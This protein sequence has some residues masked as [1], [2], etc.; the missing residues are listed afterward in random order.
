VCSRRRKS[1]TVPEPFV[2][3]LGLPMDHPEF[4][5]HFHLVGLCFDAVL[6]VLLGVHGVSLYFIETEAFI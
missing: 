5:G 3:A 4:W 2:E 1:G 6:T